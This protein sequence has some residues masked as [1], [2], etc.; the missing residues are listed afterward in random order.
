MCG[1]ALAEIASTSACD[2][3]ATVPSPEEV[4]S[5]HLGRNSYFLVPAILQCSN[6][7]LGFVVVESKFMIKYFFAML[8][9]SA[10]AE[11]L[12]R[13]SLEEFES[14]AYGA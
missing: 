7:A 6:G 11:T 8:S 10:Q 4:L 14:R 9:L 3:L 2:I 13:S 12:R 1:V 5:Y